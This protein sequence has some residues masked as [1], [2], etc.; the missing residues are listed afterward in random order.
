MTDDLEA[1]RERN[2]RER[3]NRPYFKR[4]LDEMQNFATSGYQADQTAFHSIHLRPRTN[5]S[6]LMGVL[7]PP[8]VRQSDTLF[9][10]TEFDDTL[11]FG[12]KNRNS[13]ITRLRIWVRKAMKR[14][15][16]FSQDYNSHLG[17]FARNMVNR[18]GWQVNATLRS[19]HSF[20]VVIPERRYRNAYGRMSTASL[21][22]GTGRPVWKKNERLRLF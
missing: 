2:I 5:A 19:P 9:D 16:Q 22:Q 15:M 20:G 6:K 12:I 10:D 18:G 8:G 14:R 17:G 1:R 4:V 13:I 21:D 3:A 7:G 11:I